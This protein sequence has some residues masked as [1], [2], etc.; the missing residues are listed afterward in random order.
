MPEQRREIIVPQPP[1]CV[2]R[3]EQMPEST[4]AFLGLS[5][6]GSAQEWLP[7]AKFAV[8]DTIL[9][10]ETHRIRRTI[11]SVRCER[12][13]EISDA[14]IRAEGFDCPEHD[15][16]GGMCVGPRCPALRQL[17]A[18]TWDTINARRSYAWDAN[19]W[20]FVYEWSN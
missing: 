11:T 15:F 18:E 20:V 9:V 17:F 13:Q 10:G 12:V 5:L 1:E 6:D 8:G 7:A 4:R 14:D 2:A 19:P 3:A 16:P